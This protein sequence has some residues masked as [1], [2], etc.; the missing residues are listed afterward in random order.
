MNCFTFLP[1]FRIYLCLQY[2]YHVSQWGKLPKA[3]HL[4][5]IPSSQT[6]LQS[7]AFLPLFRLLLHSLKTFTSLSSLRILLLPQCIIVSIP[8]PSSTN[9]LKE[10][11]TFT[12]FTLPPIHYPDYHSPGTFTHTSLLMTP[13]SK[14]QLKTALF[15]K[16]SFTWHSPSKELEHQNASLGTGHSKYLLCYIFHPCQSTF[17]F[18]MSRPTK[19]LLPGKVLARPSYILLTRSEKPH[20]M[21]VNITAKYYL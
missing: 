2:L 8:L 16:S 10:F 17:F 9:V 18:Y 5:L 7:T 19:A 21:F 20:F 13:L 3:N 15:R 12:T 4:L 14:E 11:F 1:L 6:P